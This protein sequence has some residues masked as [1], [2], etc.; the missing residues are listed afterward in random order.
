M[1]MVTTA[2]VVATLG[3]IEQPATSKSSAT[4]IE[5]TSSIGLPLTITLKAGA[6]QIATAS[7]APIQ[8]EGCP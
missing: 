8:I 4:L 2:F 1:R 7:F 5:L 3:G 6:K